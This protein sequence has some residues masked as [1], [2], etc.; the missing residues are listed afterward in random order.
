[1]S[2]ELIKQDG[3]MCTI[4]DTDDGSIETAT[5]SFD[6]YCKLPLKKHRFHDINPYLKYPNYNV[7]EHSVEYG[8]I[9]KVIKMEYYDIP[10]GI[11]QAHFSLSF[12]SLV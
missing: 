1:M 6:D 5:L 2:L 8:V 11:F 9:N 10:Y 12:D 4:Y 3:D 7:S